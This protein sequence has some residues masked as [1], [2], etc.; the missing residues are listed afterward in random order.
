[1]RVPF[2]LLGRIPEDDPFHQVLK[3]RTEK[4]GPP[5][6][7]VNVPGVGC[8]PQYARTVYGDQAGYDP[9]G[10]CRGYFT[11]RK[12]QMHNNCYNYALDIASNSMAQPG[13][14]HG[15]HRCGDFNTKL[16]IEGAIL[17]GL[18]LLGGKDVPLSD[19]RDQSSKRDGILVALLMAPAD[20]IVGFPGDF[21][22]VRC[23]DLECSSWSQ[24]PGT[25][26]VSNLDFAGEPITDPSRATWRLNA[27]PLKPPPPGQRDFIT[28]YKFRAW[29]FV[30]PKGVKII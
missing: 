11:L 17:D 10:D 5:P 20:H 16:I 27:G 14:I 18:Q 1:M 12:F 7:C 13:R 15:I 23:H 19:V 2:K 22:W 8:V 28:A 21:H 24:K 6:R 25:D 29:M 26:Q 9:A 4:V 3:I 30:P